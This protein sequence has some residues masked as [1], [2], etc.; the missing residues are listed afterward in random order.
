MWIS[1]CPALVILILFVPSSVIIQSKEIK[2]K[3]NLD[4]DK[5]FDNR[6]LN[7]IDGD[8]AQL[9]NFTTQTGILPFNYTE[10]TDENDE[11][12]YPEARITDQQFKSISEA[13]NW[14]VIQY[15]EYGVDV[16]PECTESKSMYRRIRKMIG[17]D[18]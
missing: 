13:L 3:G 5:L 2:E 8:I 14:A 16:H 17:K 15:S 4:V 6:G 11:Q 1:V 18:I 12:I 10:D 9:L 7:R